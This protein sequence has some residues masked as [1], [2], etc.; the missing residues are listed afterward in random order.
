MLAHD[1][2][3]MPGQ[4]MASTSVAEFRLSARRSNAWPAAAASAQQH[5]R[6]PR[7][8]CEGPH[9]TIAT[10]CEAKRGWR[11]EPT[12]RRG[13]PPGVARARPDGTV[14]ELRICIICMHV[15]LGGQGLLWQ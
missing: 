15:P 1:A 8:A 5:C 14:C 11:P 12:H 10:C 9:V 6:L 4:A 2:G 7:R 13:G 3:R